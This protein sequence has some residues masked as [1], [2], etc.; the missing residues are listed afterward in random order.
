M[1]VVRPRRSRSTHLSPSDGAD[2]DQSSLEAN[3]LGV[4]TRLTRPPEDTS[5]IPGS[6]REA[7]P[8]NGVVA[9]KAGTKIHDDRENMHVTNNAAANDFLK[10]E[11][12][13][14]WALT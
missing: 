14:G 8:G 5:A 7:F 9:L 13:E 1:P 3:A 12:R 2:D 6:T 4:T 10:R 11:Y